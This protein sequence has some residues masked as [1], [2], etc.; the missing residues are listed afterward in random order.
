MAKESGNLTVF[1]LETEFDGT[2]EFT[3]SL[4]ITGKFTGTINAKGSLEI[5]KTAVCKVDSMTAE[6]IIISGQVEGNVNAHERIE[7]CNG[8]KVK[9]DLSS[10][11]LRIGDNVDFEGQVSMLDEVPDVDIFKV[12]SSEFKNSLILK[13]DEAH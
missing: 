10:A 5:E 6:S 7:L 1:G 13:T 4:V 11:R 9:G 3:D 2:L 12:A 8:S